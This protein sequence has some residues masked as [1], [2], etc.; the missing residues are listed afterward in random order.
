M[1]HTRESQKAMF[2]KRKK[3]MTL[4]DFERLTKKLT[5]KDSGMTLK[6][7]VS[8]HNKRTGENLVF[9]KREGGLNPNFKFFKTDAERIKANKAR[10]G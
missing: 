2:A 6:E 8:T 3:I 5:N 7:I 10:F 4:D 9:G 1:A